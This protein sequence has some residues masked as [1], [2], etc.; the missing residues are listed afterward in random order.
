ML[1]YLTC[2][3]AIHTQLVT[4]VTHSVTCL[5]TERDCM[6][7]CLYAERS[8]MRAMCR[9]LAWA[10]DIVTQLEQQ[11]NELRRSRMELAS[12]QEVRPKPAL[13]LYMMI[14]TTGSLP[15]RDRLTDPNLC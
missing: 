6:Y 8:H 9:L 13:S 3:Y 10:T 1:A 11:R 4:H 2:L 12:A 14:V 7:T 15:S 5:Y